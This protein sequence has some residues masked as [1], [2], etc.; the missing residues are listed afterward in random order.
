[1]ALDGSGESDHRVRLGQ[2]CAEKLDDDLRA[3]VDFGNFN[4]TVF[5]KNV[6][7]TLGLINA[8]GFATR[9]G[10]AVLASPIRPRTIG[11]TVGASF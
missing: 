10:T 11:V 1:M 7:N 8:A 3:G 4:L 9:P 6:T 5:A 2:I